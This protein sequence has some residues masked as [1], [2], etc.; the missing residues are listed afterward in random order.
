[1]FAVRVSPGG[2]TV[3]PDAPPDSD[4][5]PATPNTVTAFDRPFRFEFRLLCDMVEVSRFTLAP[6][7]NY[8]TTTTIIA[9]RLHQCPRL[10]R[11]AGNG[12]GHQI[13][14]RIEKITLCTLPRRSIAG[15]LD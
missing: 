5:A 4:N 10:T 7:C 9:P 11:V 1:V 8:T 12:G 2:L 14:N 6:I 15:D 3:A 13:S